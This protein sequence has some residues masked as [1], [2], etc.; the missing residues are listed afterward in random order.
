M[1]D[2]CITA[3]SL[4]DMG[5]KVFILNT[6]THSHTHIGGRSQGILDRYRNIDR[7]SLYA[8]PTP[9]YR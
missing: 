1:K 5:R 2:A 8:E 7:R 9:K 3:S 4:L 6:D